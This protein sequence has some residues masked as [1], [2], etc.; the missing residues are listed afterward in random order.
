[1][2]IRPR[3]MLT[4]YPTCK[5]W[6]RYWETICGRFAA[7]PPG[8]ALESWKSFSGVWLPSSSRTSLCLTFSNTVGVPFAYLV[9]LLGWS[10]IASLAAVV[11]LTPIVRY[12]SRSVYRMSRKIPVERDKRISV[13]REMLQSVTAV[14]LNA[15]ED[16]FMQKATNAREQ[17]LR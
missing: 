16:P 15:W 12:F 14:K 17:E 10:A 3:R 9:Y 11:A 4:L 7:S 13:V 8:Y 5:S 2:C 6:S 1:M